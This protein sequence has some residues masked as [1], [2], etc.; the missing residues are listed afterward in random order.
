MFQI[1]SLIF[2]GF[3]SLA[4][5]EPITCPTDFIK[6]TL[7]E[8]PSLIATLKKLLIYDDYY[9]HN[10]P[11]KPKIPKATTI[12]RFNTLGESKIYLISVE[13]I[14]PHNKDTGFEAGFTGSDGSM[15]F[16]F[17]VPATGPNKLLYEDNVLAIYGT[18]GNDLPYPDVMVYF[19]GGA[20]HRAGNDSGYGRLRYIEKK[21][22]Y[23]RYK[24]EINST[25]LEKTCRK[26]RSKEGA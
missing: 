3:F 16:I 2:I 22:S 11:T 5:S 24:E 17:E 26:F 1:I 8:A 19:H 6:T 9:N 18:L 23:I 13:D 14:Y 4:K 15:I 25:K 10:K 21:K 20:F 12:Y 7:R